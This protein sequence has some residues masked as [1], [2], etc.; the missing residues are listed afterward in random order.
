MPP[1]PDRPKLIDRFLR[2]FGD[3]Q[4][5]EGAR[6]LVFAVN[7]FL[8]LLA[9]Y[10]LKTVREPLVLA[11][12]GGGAEMKSYAGA[13]QAVVLIGVASGFGWLASHLHR[14]TLLTVVSLFFASNLVLFFILFKALP[15]SALGLGI[16][17]YV[18][19]GCFSVMVISQFWAFANEM[20]TKKQ[21]ERLF[22]IIAAGSAIGSV[23]GAKIAKPL[24]KSLGPYPLMLV[25]AVILLVCLGL[26]YVAFHMSHGDKVNDPESDH[27]KP[28]DKKGGFALILHDKFLLFVGLLS[29]CK[30]LV[31]STGEYI[32]D[33]RLLDVATQK[34]GEDQ[35]A[36]TAFIAAF[37]SDYFTYVNSAVLVFQLFAVSRLV[38]YIGVRRSL[39]ILPIIALGGYSSMAFFPI[40][41][42]ILIAKV[43]ENSTDYSLEKT[44]EQMLYLVTSKEAK[45]KAKT[46]TDTFAVRLGDVLSA[47]VVW[48]G[49]QLKFST[50]GFILTNIGLIA[51]WLVVVFFLGRLYSKKEAE[52]PEHALPD[53]KGEGGGKG[54]GA[55]VKAG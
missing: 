40:I 14:M 2:L 38:K 42:V 4:P 48:V 27:D 3:V 7:L 10:L 28:L 16:G 54:K 32:L 17:F 31:N 8:L 41:T 55:V 39:F 20:H 51:F 15:G 35:A 47:G 53:G 29:V 13:A 25:A 44:V 5:G 18:W 52:H 24:F 19:V 45:Y 22:G 23:V 33:R 12:S 34:V 36:R 43:A 11:A 49:T 46:I 50:V 9:Y 6:L 21:G 37:K 1:I 26:T 30:N